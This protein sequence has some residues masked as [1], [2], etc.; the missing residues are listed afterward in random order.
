[1]IHLPNLES[2]KNKF[3]ICIDVFLLNLDDM[4][5]V[6]NLRLVFSISLAFTVRLL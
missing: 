2:H 6:Y 4:A 5:K 1:M 3:T